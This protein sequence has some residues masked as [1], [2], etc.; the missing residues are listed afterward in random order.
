MDEAVPA[1]RLPG[2]LGGQIYNYLS[3]ALKIKNEGGDDVRE[4]IAQLMPAGT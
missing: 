3:Q 1:S 4:R 2:L